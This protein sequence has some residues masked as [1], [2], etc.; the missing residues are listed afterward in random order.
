M[1][2]HGPEIRGSYDNY[3]ASNRDDAG[4]M[5]T[6]LFF[7]MQPFTELLSHFQA[8]ASFSL[9]LRPVESEQLLCFYKNEKN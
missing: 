8:A 7:V 9:C 4:T 1:F 3:P 2:A 6:I 5:K